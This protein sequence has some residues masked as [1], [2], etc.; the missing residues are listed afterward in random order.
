M[1]TN[2]TAAHSPTQSSDTKT[3]AQ[4]P[5]PDALRAEIAETRADLGDTVDALAAKADVRSRAK[6][7][8]AQ[9]RQAVTAA[10]GRATTAARAKTAPLTGQARTYTATAR[11]KAA[12]TGPRT[13]VTAGTAAGATLLAL[14]VALGLRR[15]RQRAAQ[16]PWYR[17][18]SRR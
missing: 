4:S 10:A 6:A 3:A 18:L 16:A 13:R 11:Q 15:R 5:D 1:T 8:L 2:P 9:R 17:R 7:S 12:A 14:V